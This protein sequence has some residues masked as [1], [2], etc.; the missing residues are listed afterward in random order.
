L[1]GIRPAS[2]SARRSSSIRSRTRSPESAAP[3]YR[4]HQAGS[5]RPV[6]TPAKTLMTVTSPA[7]VRTCQQESTASSRCGERITVPIDLD[8]RDGACMCRE[9][10]AKS[11]T[12][13]VG[14]LTATT[15]LARA[16]FA[17][18]ARIDRARSPLATAS[19]RRLGQQT[20]LAVRSRPS[21]HRAGSPAGFRDGRVATVRRP[22][23]RAAPSVTAQSRRCVPAGLLL[24][25]AH[26]WWRRQ[27]EVAHAAGVMGSSKWHAA[28]SEWLALTN[29][30]RAV[31][32]PSR[33]GC[34]H[35]RSDN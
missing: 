16:P 8:N 4:S 30:G 15:G 34:S 1:T 32:R 2:E 5:S 13:S 19:C 3:V 28:L 18:E 14:R 27:Y 20:P 26:A 9:Y 10:G 35:V 17:F 33:Y 23:R 21:G 6:G 24:Q 11:R 29:D 12:R 7:W 22:P 31:S 25:C